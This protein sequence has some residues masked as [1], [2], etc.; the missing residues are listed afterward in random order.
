L[1]TSNG[2]SPPNIVEQV[3]PPAADVGIISGLT[4]EGFKGTDFNFTL[5]D[6][7]AVSVAT[8]SDTLITF[9]P[10]EQKTSAVEAMTKAVDATSSSAVHGQATEAGYWS[11]MEFIAAIKYVADKGLPVTSGNIVKEL[12]RGWTFQVAGG[13][14]PVTYPQAHAGGGG[15]VSVVSSNGSQY[16]VPLP[17]Y[18]PPII[19]N[20]LN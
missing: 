18:C 4:H 16:S 1:L 17:L 19:A 13:T 15:C 3:L 5:Y 14:G 2:G 11:A 10:W 6:P 7:R 12:N 8:G 9:A 20:P